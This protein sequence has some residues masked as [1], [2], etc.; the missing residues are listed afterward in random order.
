MGFT[1]TQDV[2]SC[3][4]AY[5]VGNQCRVRLQ[6]EQTVSITGTSTRT[7]STQTRA[8]PGS[9]PNRVMAT[10]TANSKKLLAPIKAPGAAML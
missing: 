8:A 9:G 4:A 1:G 2:L 6:T 10:V 3:R 7:P 5:V